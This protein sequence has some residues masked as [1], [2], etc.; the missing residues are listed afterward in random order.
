MWLA[1]SYKL[2]TNLERCKSGMANQ[3]LCPK[4]GMFGESTLHALRD[5]A[6][7]RDIWDQVLDTK[8]DPSF[9]TGN[10]HEWLSSNLNN[11]LIYKNWDCIF[12][13][14]IWHL[15]RERNNRVSL[16]LQE[17]IEV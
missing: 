12:K 6:K 15:W 17:S 1:G 8:K 10:C 4:C 2:L 9:F 5:C 16:F 7:V 11:H 13:V 3:D 14:A